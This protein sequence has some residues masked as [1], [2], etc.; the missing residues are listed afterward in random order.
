MFLNTHEAKSSFLG[1]YTSESVNLYEIL[2]VKAM[3][4]HNGSEKQAVSLNDGL[5]K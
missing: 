4:L 1:P 5:E 3:S 2:R